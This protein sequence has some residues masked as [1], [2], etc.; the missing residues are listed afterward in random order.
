MTDNKLLQGKKLLLLGGAANMVNVTRLAQ[1][2]GCKVYIAD[3]YDTDRSP[4]KLIADEYTDISISDYDKVVDYIRKNN[5]D[6]VLSGFTD[7]YLM[8]YLNVCEKAGLPHYGSV[9]S[10]GVAV[11][12]MLFK[13]ACRKCGVPVIPGTNAYS[14]DEA[15]AFADD[16]EYPFMLK[17][18]DNSGSRGVIKCEREEDLKSCY[19]YALSFSESKNV[20]IEKFMDCDTIVS[21]YQFD[22]KTARLSAFCD[23]LIYEAERGGSA[24]THEARYPSKYLERYIDEVDAP[25]K[26]LFADYGFAD[27]M[28]GIMGFVDERGFY[29]CEMTYRPSGGHHYTL[30]DD[31]SGINGL[32]LL[33][34]FAVTGEV[35]NYF[36]E[37]ENPDFNE[38]C[39][40]IHIVGVPEKKIAVIEGLE[41]IEK[42]PNVLELSQE[43]RPGRTVGKEGTTAQTLLSVWLKANS[44]EEYDEL[45]KKIKSMLKVYDEEGNSLV[46]EDI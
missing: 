15:K 10:F 20:I 37:K 16:N 23:R 9:E 21:S 46:K 11:D 13:E 35:N 33:I 2:M 18:V 40:M 45:I 5:I 42:L 32:A 43:L 27:G 6:G 29:M 28:V 12:K 39:G 31:Q 1:S 7:S 30:I 3:Y 41:E 44:W 17:P 22:G 26:K 19:E 25:M 38:C 14:Y 36:P 24:F 4:A 8:H 34:E